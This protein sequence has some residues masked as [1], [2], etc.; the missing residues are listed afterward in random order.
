[1]HCNAGASMLLSNSLDWVV[2]YCST[3]LPTSLLS[4][5]YNKENVFLF[6]TAGRFHFNDDRDRDCL[7]SY[8]SAQIQDGTDAHTH[9]HNHSLSPLLTSL[10]VTRAAS[11]TCFDRFFRSH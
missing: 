4:S 6:R 1:M 2:A 5:A 10:I 11:A 9:T 3:K 8:K 7:L